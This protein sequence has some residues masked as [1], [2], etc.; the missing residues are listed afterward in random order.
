MA[1]CDN[2]SATTGMLAS[3]CRVDGI[4][5]CHRRRPRTAKT[6]CIFRFFEMSVSRGLASSD[7]AL[8]MAH[9]RGATALH[10]AARNG[11][12]PLVRYLLDHGARPSLH[13]K[14]T[15]GC[16]P[17]DV[18]RLFGPHPE[19]EALLAQAI[20]E[21]RGTLHEVA[22]VT[23]IEEPLPYPFYVLP[24]RA[25]LELSVLPRHEELLEKG[26]LVR[27][28][29]TMRSVFYVSLEWSSSTHPDPDGK[30]LDVLKQYF[31]RMVEGCAP[32]VEADWATQAAYGKGRKLTSV[33][34]KE[35]IRDAHI[36]IMFCSCPTVPTAWSD[37]TLL[38]VPGYIE[39]ATHFFALCPPVPFQNASRTCDFGSWR[40]RGLSRVELCALQLARVL[41]PAILVTG[42][43]SPTAA[44]PPQEAM[45]LPPGLGAFSCCECG[46]MCSTHDGA[47][48]PMS[49]HKPVV[50]NIVGD[51]FQQKVEHLR[52]RADWDELRLWKALVPRY[53]QGLFVE[54]P[55][56]LVT[57]GA[58]LHEFE[59]DHDAPDGTFESKR[60]VTPLLLGVLSGNVEVT[61]T[62]ALANPADVTTR[63]KSEFPLMALWVGFEVI[64]AAAA[65]TV[66]NHVA[67]IVALLEG[68]AD[69]NAAS[70]KMGITP[71]YASAVA[72]NLEGMRA[73]LI[74]AGGRLEL[75]KENQVVA[76]TALGGS[77]YFATPAIV[78]TQY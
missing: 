46:H 33:D 30:R 57:P 49:C 61:R 77:T 24:V 22:A 17:L 54:A 66:T 41:K 3:L 74:S 60:G 4:D 42:S 12:M 39:R 55:T 75:E 56:E 5:V 11:H 8:G 62:M 13:V 53:S 38:S 20:L 72:N 73:L 71:L 9:H 25:L 58:F 40:T 36:W 50:G 67:I 27:W 47:S 37:S 35:L 6:A 64:H 34:W 51:L 52:Q 18:S 45:S 65:Y 59:F 21:D 76:D 10:C 68:G 23:A 31:I 70:G 1:A 2:P 28:R 15:M 26:A 44:I 78:D 29:A 14:N 7:F 63:L 16:T 19:T 32:N 69:P 48:F 43:D